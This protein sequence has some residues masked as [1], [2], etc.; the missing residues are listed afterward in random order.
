MDSLLR[1][2]SFAN[3]DTK[4]I[5][6]QI[7]IDWLITQME[8]IGGVERFVLTVLPLL[9]DRGWKIRLIT[10][11]NDQEY[12]Q[13]LKQ[14]GI[15][16]IS[17]GARRKW[18]IRALIKLIRLWRVSPPI[19]LHTHLYHA[20][21]LGRL[22]GWYCRIPIILCHQ[23]GPELDRNRWRSELDSVTSKLVT[24]YLTSSQAVAD[25][26]HQREGIPVDKITPIPNGVAIPTHPKNYT[27]SKTEPTINLITIGRLSPEKDQKTLIKSVM[28]LTNR[29]IPF[30]LDILGE[31]K[32]KEALIQLAKSLNVEKFITFAGFQNHPNDW[33]EK[34]DIFILPSKWE[35]ISL[36]LL[37]AMAMGL[38]VIATNTGGTGEVVHN[39]QN[40]LLV[41]PNNPIEITNAI[42]KLYK[43]PKYRQFLGYNGRKFIEENYSIEITVRKIE[44]LYLSIL[45]KKANTDYILSHH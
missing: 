19:I 20:A 1:N 5:L 30:H 16:V 4:S 9:S 27:F 25:I 7:S 36:A 44:E 43:Q 18:D 13:R 8:I 10:L 26:L 2:A 32:E 24:R 31:G 11:T 34:A 23:A 37:E 6:H 39:G 3:R 29:G 28:E 35:G 45:N 38:A 17:L 21:I 42:E 33:L 41:E 14:Q 12:S 40:G 15:K 22:A